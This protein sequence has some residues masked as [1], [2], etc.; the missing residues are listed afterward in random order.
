MGALVAAAVFAA[1]LASASA[2]GTSGL[3]AL[4]ND[5]AFK[6]F[7]TTVRAP[8]ASWRGWAGELCSAGVSF[9]G[10]ALAALARSSGR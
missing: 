10:A 7:I 8:A 6:P 9:G 2:Q 4:L 3:A 5:P 1:L